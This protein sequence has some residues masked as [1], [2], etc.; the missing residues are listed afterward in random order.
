MTDL[1][2]LE[3]GQ[4]QQMILQ[5]LWENGGEATILQ[6][7]DRIEEKCGIRLSCAAINTMILILVDKGLVERTRRI[8]HAYVFRAIIEEEEFRVR[9][10]RRIKKLTYGNSTKALITSMLEAGITEAERK[11]AI[12]LL[13]NWKKED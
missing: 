2:N 6:I 13:R 9:E 3:L 1:D 8:S 7:V 5:S 4:R 11:E 10:L 12:R